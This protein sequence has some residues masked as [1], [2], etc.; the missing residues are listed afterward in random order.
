MS[1]DPDRVAAASAAWVWFPDDATAVSAEDHLLVRWP[2]YFDAPPTLLRTDPDAHPDEVL[3][4]VTDRV[5]AWG[6]ATVECWVKLDA[7]PGLEEALAARGAEAGEV[8]DVFALDLAAGVPDL[9]PPAEVETRWQLDEATTRDALGVAVEAFGEGSVP[10]DERVRELAEEA[11][12]AHREGWGGT[13]VAYLDGRPVG[14]GGLTLAEDV[15]RL[16]GGG[17]VPAARGRG[18]YRALLAARLEHA[19]RRGATMAL[20]KGRVDTSAPILLRAG[21]A[22]YGQERAYL[23]PV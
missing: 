11:A 16:W 9:D 21:F 5:R 4:E 6:A 3:D 12:A 18:V 23:L 15:A 22:A 7:P 13:S 19:V 17:V 20:V 2:A 8:V 1:L 14:S 10:P